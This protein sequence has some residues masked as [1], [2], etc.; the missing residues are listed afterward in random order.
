MHRII[1]AGSRGFT[2]Y[3]LLKQVLSNYIN[4]MEIS[5]IEIPGL[6]EELIN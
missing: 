5:Q 3:E 1:I 6:P 2:N 4:R